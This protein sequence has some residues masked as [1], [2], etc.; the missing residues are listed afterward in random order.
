M[1][2]AK[3]D[4][5]LCMEAASPRMSVPMPS[6]PRWRK[7]L[8]GFGAVAPLVMLVPLWVLAVPVGFWMDGNHD[9]SYPVGLGAA[10]AG[11]AVYVVTLIAALVHVARRSD[12][13]VRSRRWWMIGV[14]FLNAV[15]LPVF[16]QQ[17][18]RPLPE[19]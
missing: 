5:P 16:W 11:F 8:W 4:R 9:G 19:P 18:I 14:V 17:L 3:P 10:Y 15:L 1:R 2:R 12:I 6:M 7:L 13:P